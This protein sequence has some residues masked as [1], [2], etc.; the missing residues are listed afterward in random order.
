MVGLSLGMGQ[1]AHFL[2]YDVLGLLS[3]LPGQHTEFTIFY[4]Q[5]C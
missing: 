1:G 4:P 3:H 2:A 5:H